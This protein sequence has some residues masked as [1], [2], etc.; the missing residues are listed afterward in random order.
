MVFFDDWRFFPAELSDHVRSLDC[1]G[2]GG[3]ES[4][5]EHRDKMRATA[6]FPE[7]DCQLHRS[8]RGIVWEWLGGVASV[9]RQTGR[10]SGGDD[11]LGS[12]VE[13]VE[14]IEIAEL[15]PADGVTAVE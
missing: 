9:E 6:E 15:G 1:V 13:R 8:G 4:R 3:G 7:R 12:L 11:G 10:V 14:S 5:G 2:L